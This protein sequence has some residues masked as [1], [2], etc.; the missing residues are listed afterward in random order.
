MWLLTGPSPTRARMLPFSLP[1]FPTWRPPPV[2][3]WATLQLAPSA[4][5]QRASRLPASSFWDRPRAPRLPS[6]P[7]ARRFVPRGSLLCWPGR[8]SDSIHASPEEVAESINLG[9]VFQLPCSGGEAG[10]LTRGVGPP[11]AGWAPPGTL[12]PASD[13]IKRR[14]R[15]GERSRLAPDTRTLSAATREV[16][17]EEPACR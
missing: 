10:P 16:N 13:P 7:G 5:T 11:G 17:A 12:S 14:G 6:S 8:R 9:L 1:S 15:E 2:L 3:I 4:S